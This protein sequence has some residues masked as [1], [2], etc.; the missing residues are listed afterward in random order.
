MLCTCVCE[1]RWTEQERLDLV[2]E[3][4]EQVQVLSVSFRKISTGKQT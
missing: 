4:E 3:T 1:K 2:E